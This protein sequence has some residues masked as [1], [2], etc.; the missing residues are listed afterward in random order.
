MVRSCRQVLDANRRANPAGN[1]SGASG[2]RASVPFAIGGDD[3]GLPPDIAR[4]IETATADLMSALGALL[5]TD[6]D[7]Q[8]TNPLSLFR[9]ATRPLTV[10]LERAGCLPV[11][12]DP[13][14]QRRFGDDLYGIGPATWSDIDDRLV[15]PGLG[16]GAWKAMT[17]LQRRRA[18]G[19]R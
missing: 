6:V 11:A 9:D 3:A 10:E 1:P 15:E 18:D 14:E 12:R 8:S 5:A 4:A 17:I 16:W 2:P 19:L 13:F 7:E